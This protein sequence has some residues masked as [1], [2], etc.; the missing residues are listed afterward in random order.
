MHVSV[1]CDDSKHLIASKMYTDLD[2]ILYCHLLLIHLS[3]THLRRS[4]TLHWGIRVRD[5][6]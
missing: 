1:F 4:N 3:T 5:D 6:I 2:L